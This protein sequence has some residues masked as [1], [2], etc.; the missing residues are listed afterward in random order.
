M[1]FI[2]YIYL[3]KLG[4]KV[5]VPSIG[6][7]NRQYGRFHPSCVLIRGVQR[8]SKGGGGETEERGGRKLRKYTYTIF[9]KSIAKCIKCLCAPMVLII[10]ITNGN[11]LEYVS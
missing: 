10:S 9:V 4:C 2:Q 5:E 1:C 7:V 8:H 6:M 3:E 11:I